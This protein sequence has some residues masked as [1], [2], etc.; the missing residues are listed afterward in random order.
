MA[1]LNSQ[2]VSISISHDIDREMMGQSCGLIVD[3]D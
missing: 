2:R 1:M 3:K